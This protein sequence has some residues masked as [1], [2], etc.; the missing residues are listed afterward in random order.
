MRSVS[1]A[2]LHEP[3]GEQ[4]KTAFD[5]LTEGPVPDRLLELAAKLERA[6]QQGE[7]RVA[8]ADRLS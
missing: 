6:L 8:K 1:P 3:M 2:V 5:R 7:I 4:L